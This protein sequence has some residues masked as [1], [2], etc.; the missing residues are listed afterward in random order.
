[1]WHFEVVCLVSTCRASV[2]GCCSNFTVRPPATFCPRPSC[3]VRF[4]PVRRLSWCLKS[5]DRA[6]YST[7]GL[8]K[9]K[10]DA[11]AEMN[12][13]A[14]GSAWNHQ[15]Q[16]H[17]PESADSR[18]HLEAQA[19]TD[20][21]ISFPSTCSHTLPLF[22]LTCVWTSSPFRHQSAFCYQNWVTSNFF[23]I[24]K[25]AACRRVNPADSRWLPDIQ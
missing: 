1:M 14:A 21:L 6:L 18:T 24:T 11:A 4:P 16:K 7:A 5:S 20:D 13:Q 8:Q 2:P 15:N 19:S 22:C 25:R 23:I 17:S 3:Q 10:L 9:L 12:A